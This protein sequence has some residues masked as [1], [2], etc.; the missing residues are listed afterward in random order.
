VV[1][2]SPTSN[3]GTLKTLYVDNS[4]IEHSYLQFN[5]QGLKKAPSKVT[6]QIFANSTSSTGFD[7]YSVSNNSW[8]ETG[9]TYSNAPALAASKTGSS[10]AIKTSGAFYSVDVTT[11]VKGN[12][13]VSFG[14]ATTGGTAINLSSRESGAN[15]PRLVITP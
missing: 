13:T 6:L 14:L 1:S 8:T 3:F 2:T 10:G 5:V 12:G 4:P 11:L 9:I 15:A 7:V